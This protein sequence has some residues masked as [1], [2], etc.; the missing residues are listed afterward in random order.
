LTHVGRQVR[1]PG[2]IGR[3]DHERDA[4]VVTDSRTWLR[5][6]TAV[7]LGMA[8]AALLCAV[9]YKIRLV[10]VPF[11]AGFVVA[12]IL[13]PVLDKL[14]ARGWSRRRA[15]WTV[16]GSLL[17]LVTVLLI[18]LVPR[19]VGEVGDA[20]QNR[21][22][23]GVR[24][25]RFYDQSRAALERWLGQYLPGTAAAEEVDRRLEQLKQWTAARMGAI[26]AWF[27]GRLMQAV[28]LIVLV[29][30]GMLVAFHFM[31]ILDPLRDTVQRVFLT[32]R[33]SEDMDIIVTRVN[34]MLGAYVRGMAVVSILVGIATALA[35]S[36]LSMY[37]GTRYALLIG[38]LAGV[39]YAVPWIG[40]TASAGTAFFFG[41]VTADHHALLAAVVCGVVVI[42]IN[43]L[44]DN[45]LMPRIVGQQ[46][47]LHPLLVLFA[48]MA[49]FQLFGLI[50]I[51]IAVP[52]AASIRIAILRWIPLLPEDPEE[53]KALPRIDFGRV[54]EG[55]SHAWSR[56]TAPITHVGPKPPPEET[57]K[58][59]A[60]E[61]E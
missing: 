32:R 2:V 60:G 19:V 22:E 7:C 44:S 6:V 35:L 4:G 40:Q 43:Q 58:P 28:A 27:G 59:D 51:V 48:M 25:E 45:I 61:H 18:V 21:D 15:V 54:T 24:M 42:A 41:L 37:F 13:D 36:G 20:W 23:Y 30:L 39:T 10:F 46:V 1:Q 33:Q 29:G 55:L 17:T 12:Y 57:P 47:G 14:E 56:F 38:L 52:T 49:G 9:V 3:M 50:G 53:P 8:L 16:M 26:L 5:T 11:A 31:L 34:R